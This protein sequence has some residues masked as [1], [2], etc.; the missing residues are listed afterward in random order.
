MTE[1]GA[2]DLGDQQR[3][4]MLEVS[5]SSGSCNIMICFAL[6]LYCLMKRSK[7]DTNETEYLPKQTNKQTNKQTKKYG[8]I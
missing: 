3:Y 7:V 5:K 2:R 6:H 4:N 8:T 1:I